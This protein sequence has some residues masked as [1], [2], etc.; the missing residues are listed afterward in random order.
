VLSCSDCLA[1]H[2]EYLDGLMDAA[3][4]AE[5][6][7]HLAGCASCA[8][9]DRVIRRGVKVLAA[10][11]EVEPSTDFM[12]HLQQRLLQ[13]DRR[14]AMRPM[15]SLASASVAIAA[16]LAFAAWIPVLML[17]TESDRAVATAEAQSVSAAASEIAWHVEG[18]VERRAPEHIHLARRVAWAP[19]TADNVIE[20]KYTPVVLESP[21][22]PLTY[23]RTQYGAD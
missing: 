2:S 16:M 14:A 8:R 3:T 19:S 7:S 15:T 23:S 1:R 21:I 6:R 5:W 11:A 13:E 9:Y 17:A 4:A 18:A 12:T 20:P 10:Q 22:A